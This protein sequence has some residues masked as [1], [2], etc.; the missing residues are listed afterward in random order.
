M[1]RLRGA[2]VSAAI[3][4]GIGAAA[5]SA[6]QFAPGGPAEKIDEIA[7]NHPDLNTE[8]VD[9]C[10]IQSPDGL[11]LYMASN[12]PGGKGGLDI[13]VATRVSRSDP[14]GEPVNLPEPINSAADDFCP[15]P[16]QA[17][18]LLFVSR[19]V[20][21]GVTCG[22]G[23]IYFARRN[24]AHGWSDPE[25]LGCDPEGPNRKPT[26]CST[27]MLLLSAIVVTFLSSTSWR[28]RRVLSATVAGLLARPTRSYTTLGT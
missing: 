22:M 18:G 2:L 13:W 20:I 28:T 24:P 3:L 12:R 15:T 8:F 1:N 25:H 14:W 17:D 27:W 4:V 10:P 11:S 9:G 16:I 23:D 7:G 21:E 19:R 5:A 26:T 6:T